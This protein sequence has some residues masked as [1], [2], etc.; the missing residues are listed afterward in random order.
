MA[1]TIAK[2]TGADATRTKSTTRLGSKYAEAQ[3]NTWRTFATVTTFA[4]GSGTFTLT[5]GGATLTVRWVSESEAIEAEY[6]PGSWLTH[7]H[8]DELPVAV[9]AEPDMSRVRARL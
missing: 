7:R 2:A 4:D 8:F 9:G 6:E 1:N 3:A 5:R